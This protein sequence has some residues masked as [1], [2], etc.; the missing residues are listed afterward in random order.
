MEVWCIYI[1]MSRYTNC[2]HATYR[3]M[4]F[5]EHI[6]TTTHLFWYNTTD[7]TSSLCA[8]IQRDR[9]RNCKTM[10]KKSFGQC[11]SDQQNGVSNERSNW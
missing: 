9:I 1:L 5:I 7:C 8:R 11:S 2:K 4:I 3:S 6:Y 10:A